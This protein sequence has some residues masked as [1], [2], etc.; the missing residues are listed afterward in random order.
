[1]FDFAADRRDEGGVKGR[2]NKGLVTMDR[3]TKKDS[4]YLYKAWW[5]DEPFVHICG[6]RYKERSCDTLSIKV[7]SNQPE[8]TLYLD[9]SLVEEK[10]AARVFLFENL[11]FTEGSH[12]ITAKYHDLEN[13]IVL[14]RVEQ[15]NPVYHFA[16]AEDGD[17]LGS[18]QAKEV[19]LPAVS[20]LVGMKID[21]TTLA[22]MS[23]RTIEDLAPMLG[24]MDASEEKI[25]MLNAALQKVKKEEAL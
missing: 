22:A 13:T 20:S 7:Y 16:G 8:I 11:P 18:E 4:F 12:T 19:F 3:R 14:T 21:E 5:S 6:R 2:N 9:G 15:E 1:M 25:A 24:I 17:I 23:T 10:S